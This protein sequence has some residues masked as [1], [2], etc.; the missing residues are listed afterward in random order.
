MFF[1]GQTG[2][3]GYVDRIVQNAQQQALDQPAGRTGGGSTTSISRTFIN[4]TNPNFSGS[5]GFAGGI[6]SLI[7]P[8]TRP[9]GTGSSYQTISSGIRSTFRDSTG[10]DY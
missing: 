3:R 1:V 2:L 6:S 9:T 4:T 10:S 7:S 5:P 8:S